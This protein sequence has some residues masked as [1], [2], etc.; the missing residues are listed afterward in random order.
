MPLGLLHISLSLNSLT[1]SSSGVIVAHLMPTLYFKIALAA[2]TV[3]LS[4]VWV[5]FD[6]RQNVDVNDVSHLIP[7]FQTEVEVLDIK[8]N[9]WE[10]EL[11]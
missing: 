4:F 8:L 3:T 7:V 10:N 6:E 9:I 5:D 2:S 11:K 1:R